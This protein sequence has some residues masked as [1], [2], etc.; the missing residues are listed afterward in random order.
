MSIYD[1]LAKKPNGDIVSMQTYKDKVMLIVNTALHCGFTYQFDDL[2][3]IY[4]KYKNQPF[5]VLGFPSNQFGNQNPEDGETT[6]TVCRTSFGV[7][8]PMY[9]GIEVNGANTHPLF[10]FLKE[11]V[12]VKSLEEADMQEK[13]LHAKIKDA[14][15]ENF[16]GNNIRWNFTK[17]LV[18]AN[19]EVIK[20]FEPTDSI[21]DVETAIENLL[22]K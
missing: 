20:R 4:D 7:Q 5:T 13:I 1:F 10:Q 18:N 3:R 17:F 2:Q 11:A 15:P 22:H 21:L 19:G 14:N 12:P 6:A 16:Y 9:E 8:F